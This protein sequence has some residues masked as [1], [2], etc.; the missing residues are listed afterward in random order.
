M[1]P[2]SRAL[3][4]AF[5]PALLASAVTLNGCDS[6]ESGDGPETGSFTARATG[7]ESVSLR[8]IAGFAT[9]VQDGE[10][11]FAI[12]LVNG[13]D[14]DSFDG[15]AVILVGQGT[16]DEGE[17]AIS[18]EEGGEA[19]ALFS[20]ATDDEDGALYISDTGSFTITSASSERVRGTFEFHAVS[21]DETEEVSVSGSFDAREGE[22]TETITSVR[23]LAA[24]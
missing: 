23:H 10:P 24:E 22:V 3:R 16:P 7:S 15:S 13:T 5:L 1:S 12:G 4:A 19:G 21:I 11:L 20:V 8:G 2:L 17:Y 9:D 6:S 18:N 14:E